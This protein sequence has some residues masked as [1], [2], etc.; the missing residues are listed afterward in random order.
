[1]ID[2]VQVLEKPLTGFERETD[3][4][5]EALKKWA[6]RLD[7]K[8]VA[9]YGSG[10]NARR[11]IEAFDSEFEIVCV[12]DESEIGKKIKDFETISFDSA[13]DVG[14]DVVLIAAEFRSALSVFERIGNLCELSNIQLFDMYGNDMGDL[15]KRIE[16]A[17]EMSVE[18]QLAAID[19][20]DVLVV[21][22]V[23]ISDFANEGASSTVSS[24]IRNRGP[25][26]HSI[27][28]ILKYEIVRG[29]TVVF[30]SPDPLLTKRFAIDLLAT[31]GIGGGYSLALQSET[32]MWPENGLYRMIYEKA[33]DARIVHIGSSFFDDCFIPLSYGRE[34]LLVGEWQL[35]YTFLF[36]KSVEKSMPG[37]WYV[38]DNVLSC[39]GPEDRLRACIA[40]CASS[41][42]PNIGENAFQISSIISVLT[43][44][45]IIWLAEN[46]KSSSKTI[47]K[48]LFA[49]RDGF[50]V[51]KAYDKFRNQFPNDRLPQSEYFYTSRLSSQI[52]SVGNLSYFSSC[53]LGLGKTYAFV[54]FVGAGTC[55]KQ[56]E[57]HTPFDLVGFY[58]G[59]RVGDRLENGMNAN[60]FFDKTHRSFL[61]RYL[62]LEP[63]FSSD[64]PCLASFT[65]NG[66]PVFNKELRSEKEI[67]F[68][69]DVHAGAEMLV[70]E[71]YS[72]WYVRG[73]VIDR[74]FICSILCAL[75]QCNTSTMRL[76]DD[77]SGCQITKDIVENSRRE[78]KRIAVGS[79]EEV[80]RTVQDVLLDLL[81]AFDVVCAMFGL[82]YIATH[83]TLLGAVRHGGFVPWDDDLDIAM[84]REDYDRL[85]ELAAMGVFPEPF[86][87]QTPENDPECFYGG[88]AKLRDS[89]SSAIEIDKRGHSFNQGI[90]MDIMPL[91]NC[92]SS[93]SALV[94][95]RRMVALWK[96]A[97]YAKTYGIYHVWGADP[98]KLS[99]FYAVGDKLS[100]KSLCKN[101]KQA[102]STAK[103]SGVLTIFAGNYVARYKAATY[104][105]EDISAAVRMP[106]EDT[107]IPVPRNAETWLSRYYGTD[108]RTIPAQPPDDNGHK[109]IF[110]PNM[111]YREFLKELAGRSQS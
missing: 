3:Y 89:S 40:S 79:N 88:Y 52:S 57:S 54:E 34:S 2:P 11:I 61:T 26:E 105:A 28:Q 101:L 95:R 60:V 86:F 29:K 69:N 46:L 35:P 83:G 62:S 23:L 68:L 97:L 64:E 37:N 72:N 15:R 6:F 36:E 43:I 42:I 22:F 19:S 7:G 87:L 30:Y 110:N 92:P 84:P 74:D 45:F 104:N 1:M 77:L 14:V 50:I 73:D 93:H 67:A 49:S 108:W 12:I 9:L 103:P 21:D 51:K 20:C 41:V 111:P 55:Q 56:L 66:S 5:F 58:F 59:S 13:M 39:G 102:C 27:L 78:K 109:A 99:A 48:V 107:T 71:Y 98:Y 75:D 25:I 38:S 90:W 100:R 4:R 10:A 70:N 63:F 85:I 53:G 24:C 33:L 16:A 65:E 106:F 80:K 91:D 44:G 96:R 8:R 94:R 32:K 18:D 76:F 82:T 47:D 81:E 17:A 31:L